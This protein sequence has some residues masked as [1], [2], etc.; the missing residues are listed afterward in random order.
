MQLVAV[1]VAA[2]AGFGAGAVWYMING[3]RWMAAVGRTED[4]IKA[5]K[6]PLP[7]IIGFLASLVTAGMMRHIFASA[8]VSGLGGGLIGGL[9]IGLFFIAPWIATNYAFS[10][11]PKTLW[12]IDC[13]HVILAATVIGLVLGLFL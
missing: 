5:D 12:W 4:E 9:G 7:F 6:S 2:A 11:R 13:G 10:A 8:G 1:L 3:Q